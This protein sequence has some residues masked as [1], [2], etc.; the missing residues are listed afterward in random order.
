MAPY[1]RLEH[2]NRGQDWV[3][4][5]TGKPPVGEMGELSINVKVVSGWTRDQF[6]DSLNQLWRVGDQ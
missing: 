4:M 5:V 6:N 2:S 1:S 3:A